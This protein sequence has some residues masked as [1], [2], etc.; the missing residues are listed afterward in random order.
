M[1]VGGE[2]GDTYIIKFHLLLHYL[3]LV[4]PQDGQGIKEVHELVFRGPQRLPQAHGVVRRELAL[5]QDEEPPARETQGQS[6]RVPEWQSGREPAGLPTPPSHLLQAL[7]RLA[8][9]KPPSCKRAARSRQPLR[10]L[11]RQLLRAA[12]EPARRPQLTMHAWPRQP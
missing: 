7:R 8:Y 4:L 10:Q 11:L 1:G 5:V 6:G 12:K 9:T 3:V 2:G